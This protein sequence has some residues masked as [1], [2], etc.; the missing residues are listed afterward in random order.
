MRLL[1]GAITEGLEFDGGTIYKEALG[2]SESAFVFMMRELAKRGHEVHAFTKCPEPGNYDGV[3]YHK[4]QEF[5]NLAGIFEFDVLFVY[6]HY[7]WLTRPNHAKQRV[8]VNHD[9]LTPESKMHLMGSLWQT[10]LIFN[11]SEYHKRQYCDLLPRLEPH[12]W[13]TSNGIDLPAIDQATRGVKR[14]KKKFVYGSRPERGLDVLLRDIWPK[15]YEADPERRLHIAGYGSKGIEFPEEVKALYA[16]ID[17][18][19]EQTP[20]VVRAGQLPKPEWYKLLASSALYL[21]PSAFQEIFFISGAESQACRTPVI[22]TD[23]FALPET[24]ASEFCRIPGKHASLEYQEKF[25]QKVETLLSDDILCGNIQ[26]N[27]RKHAEKYDWGLTAKSWEEKV[28]SYFEERF[29]KNKHWVFRQL[30]FNSDILAAKELARQEGMP[31]ELAEAEAILDRARSY[32]DEYAAD[33]PEVL[34]K[35]SPDFTDLSRVPTI[36]PYLKDAKTLL[37]IGCHYAEHSIGL[38]NLYP[39]LKV[40]ATDFSP[41]C[42]QQA[43]IFRETVARH[44]KNVSLRVAGWEEALLPDEPRVDAV[45]AGEILE[46]VED[47]YGFI[48]KIESYVKPSGIVIFTL[49]SGPWEADSLRSPARFRPEDNRFHISN[50]EFRDVGDLFSRKKE[51]TFS[52]CPNGITKRGELVGNWVMAY[53]ADA[54]PTGEIDLRRKFLTTRPYPGVS[55]CLIVG[56]EE[57]NIRRCLKSI[58][59][60][61]DEIIIM[62]TPA[63]QDRTLEIASEVTDRLFITTS[64]PLD[65]DPKILQQCGPGDFG[66]WRNESIKPARY[67]WIFWIDADEVLTG[68]QGM[69]KYLAGEIFNG[70]VIRQHHLTI[71]IPPGNL[72]PDVPVRLFRNFRGFSFYGCVSG[73]TL[74]DCP[75][76]MDKH[77]DGIPIRELEGR[78][79]LWVYTCHDQGERGKAFPGRRAQWV[80]KTRELAAVMLLTWRNSG[81]GVA[82]ELVATP[83]HPVLLESGQYARMDELKTGML[84]QGFNSRLSPPWQTHEVVAVSHY[85]HQDVYNME[86]EGVHNFVAN[87]I[88][89]HNCLHEH[90]MESL[91]QPIDPAFQLEDVNIA[92]FGYITEAHRREKCY[93]RNLKLLMK[94]RLVYPDR[95]L[96]LILLQRDYLNFVSLGLEETQG[97]FSERIIHWLQGVCAIHRQKFQDPTDIYWKLSYAL[98]QQALRWL[99]LARMPVAGCPTPP[100]EVGLWLGGSIGGLNMEVGEGVAPSRKWFADVQEYQVHLQEMQER[101]VSVL[102]IVGE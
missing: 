63:C 64:D 96:G 17:A 8:L 76:D 52:Y 97:Q 35:V 59:D 65:R 98:Y 83:E 9:I 71:D 57:D 72:V 26:R 78:P 53:R 16:H 2:G 92:H 87:E 69:K 47:P 84:L 94:D 91:N 21:Y 19:I 11:L 14:D 99:G 22:C 28:L 39:E 44:P 15:L 46:H 20:G 31:E 89:V 68:G 86:V 70:F 93:Q 30:L 4:I 73:D 55:A 12:I 38:S 32:K 7:G 95:T 13:A 90:A 101:L 60:V 74:V 37:E 54:S 51:F 10:D 79:D 85:G 33:D 18:L 49:P 88:V 61:V 66:F 34:T 27:G 6:R 42:I 100:F 40:L 29:Q 41:A 82:G 102:G 36:A 1:I 75:R 23:D 25:I 62:G 56:D 80:E 5:N 24:I 81:R 48:G 3:G 77:P 43:M 50:F 45:F 58:K 67:P